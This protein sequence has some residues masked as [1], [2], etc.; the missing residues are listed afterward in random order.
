MGTLVAF[1]KKEEEYVNNDF[2]ERFMNRYNSEDTIKSYT[3][4]IKDFFQVDNIYLVPNYRIKNT[5]YR[6]AEDYIYKLLKENKSKNTIKQTIGCLRALF[7][8]AM[9]KEH[10]LTN[11]NHFA[12][13]ELQNLIKLNCINEEETHGRALNLEEIKLLID[14]IKNYPVKTERKKLDLLRDELLFNFMFRT[15]LRESEVIDFTMDN[16][17]YHSITGK[18][19]I[20]I[21]GKGNKE[22][23][24]QLT[25]EMHN[26]LLEWDK[27]NFKNTVFGFNSTS[28]I[29]KIVEKW[30]KISGVK[31]ITP[32]TFRYSFATNLANNGMP[33]EKLQ[34][35]LGHSS[36]LT[37]QIYLKDTYKYKQNMD[38]YMTW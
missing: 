8:H 23:V 18:Y 2:M 27:I 13:P 34:K 33:L 35:I 12:D 38:E 3:R 24:I 14:T 16:I 6:N 1:Q 37:T 4:I 36:L 10:N 17:I 5:S 19:F 28:N 30:S 29:N 20:K 7:N 22:R 11:I 31:N 21:V 15:G 9:R 32:H 25:D 26:E